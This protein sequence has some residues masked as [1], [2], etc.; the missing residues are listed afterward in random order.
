MFINNLGKQS[1][2]LTGY[3]YTL[4]ELADSDP[5]WVEVHPSEDDSS[6]WILN[7]G[8][9]AKLPP[10]GTVLEGGDSIA[11]EL[12][13]T[14]SVVGDFSLVLGVQSNVGGDTYQFIVLAG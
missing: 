12:K 9:T 1:L 5:D 7:D 6:I 3:A 14:A 13:F 8:F 4:D 11:V 2:Q 10:L